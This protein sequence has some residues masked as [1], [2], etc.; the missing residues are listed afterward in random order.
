MG[1]D[2]GG[3]GVGIVGLLHLRAFL[4][5]FFL[6]VTQLVV[7]ARDHLA[8]ILLHDRGRLDGG[9]RDH[10]VGAGERE[11]EGGGERGT[12]RGRRLLGH[13]R[14]RIPQAGTADGA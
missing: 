11:R 14:L 5:E 13:L 6:R 3:L 2:E 1:V 4:Q 8:T 10:R 7:G 9:V 12:D